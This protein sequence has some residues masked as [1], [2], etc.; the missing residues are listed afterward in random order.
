MTAICRKI[1]FWL[2][3]VLL[4]L[5]ISLSFYQHP[6]ADD[7]AGSHLA[8]KLGIAGTIQSYRRSLIKHE[9]QITLDL[10]P[11]E[12]NQEFN[13]DYKTFQLLKGNDD[14]TQGRQLGHGLGHGW[15][16]LLRRH[17]GRHED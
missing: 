6:V 3:F 4:L 13:E 10:L 12:V 1:L 2:P 14:P 17:H 9:D 5:L 8:N 11:K 7:F 16:M 15:P